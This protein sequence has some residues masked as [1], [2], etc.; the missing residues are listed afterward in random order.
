MANKE[1]RSSLYSGELSALPKLPKSKYYDKRKKQEGKY[2]MSTSMQPEAKIV[3]K[4]AA[5]IKRQQ[6]FAAMEIDSLKTLNILFA[7][8]ITIFPT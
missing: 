6:T 5:A 7:Q 2:K 3:L 4:A 8:V 1:L